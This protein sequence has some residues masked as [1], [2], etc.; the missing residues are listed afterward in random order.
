M[1]TGDKLETAE[2]I[3]KS[4]N[5]IKEGMLVHKLTN[6]D[7]VSNKSDLHSIKLNFGK[8]ENKAIEKGI[9]IEGHSLKQ[10]MLDED[11]T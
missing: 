3:A 8:T 7:L 4:C 10:I 6:F 2:N 11:L 1:L 9:I 5:M